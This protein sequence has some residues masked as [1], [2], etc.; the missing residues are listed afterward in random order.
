[1]QPRKKQVEQHQ[2]DCGENFDILK[3]ATSDAS[4]ASSKEQA[5][6]DLACLVIGSSTLQF[7]G[8]G[9]ED[10]PTA[11]TKCVN[12]FNMA[13]IFYQRAKYDEPGIDCME[14]FGG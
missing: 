3:I 7:Y 11:W 14:L 6:Y 5:F 13:S 9:M 1:M 2:D 4:E 10:P 12:S 8:S